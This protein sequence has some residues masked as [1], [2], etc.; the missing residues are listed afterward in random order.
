MYIQ[1]V[2]AKKNDVEHTYPSIFLEAFFI[3]IIHRTD[4]IIISPIRNIG[5]CLSISKY[6]SRNTQIDSQNC[7][8]YHKNCEWP[9][10]KGSTTS[11]ETSNWYIPIQWGLRM[12]RSFCRRHC[13]I[14]FRQKFCVCWFQFNYE[15][16][17]EGQIYNSLL[18]Q[19]T[20]RGLFGHWPNQ[21]WPSSLGDINTCT[22][23]VLNESKTGQPV[24]VKGPRRVDVLNV[25]KPIPLIPYLV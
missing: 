6:M 7:G 15:F 19:V 21:W 18:D 1:P 2:P 14:H 22:P 23:L 20:T 4:K 5:W 16:V 11:I 17:S 8:L 25:I 13:L 10:E 12:L 9:F 3:L 24:I